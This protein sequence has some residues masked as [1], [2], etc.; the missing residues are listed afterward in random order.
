LEPRTDV[1]F[2]SKPVDFGADGFALRARFNRVGNG[3]AE[4]TN[5]QMLR[6]GTYSASF[7]FD[8]EACIRIS[9][10]FNVSLRNLNLALKV[11]TLQGVDVLFQDTRLQNEM[12][13][14]Y[15]A[16]SE[17]VFEWRLK[18]PLM[19]GSYVL[20]CGLAHPPEIAGQDW[21]FVDMV[22]LAYEFGMAPRTEGMIGGF[23]TLPAR[24]QILRAEEF[25]P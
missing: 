22:P 18:L 23:V 3:D 9:A 14:I 15:K 12:S 7:D 17:Y 21:V 8:D 13:R 4:I 19:H 20:S 24:L 5:I 11:R 16:G 25:A 2:E 1:V 6:N 10:R